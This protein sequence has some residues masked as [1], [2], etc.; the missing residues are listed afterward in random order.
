MFDIKTSVLTF[1]RSKTEE[2]RKTILG[3]EGFAIEDIL[4][5]VY[6]YLIY[7]YERQLSLYISAWASTPLLIP[8]YTTRRFKKNFDKARRTCCFT[9]P[10]LFMFFSKMNRL[11]NPSNKKHLSY[12][13]GFSLLVLFI[14]T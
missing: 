7:L 1:K 8:G 10:A 3:G 12:E 4:R 6:I 14:Q 2:E 9:I 13:N 11:G 5:D